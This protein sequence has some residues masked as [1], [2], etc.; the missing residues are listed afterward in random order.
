MI[1]ALVNLKAAMVLLLMSP[2]SISCSNWRLIT[3]NAICITSLVDQML[4]ISTTFYLIK[5]KIYHIPTKG[6]TPN[7]YHPLRWMLYFSWTS[8]TFDSFP[9]SSSCSSTAP[10]RNVTLVCLFVFF[11]LICIWFIYSLWS[12]RKSWLPPSFY[13]QKL[14]I[15]ILL[16]SSVYTTWLLSYSS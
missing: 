14:S 8:D 2:I 5:F 10:P 9:P 1:L 7:A 16:G 11:P 3:P 6:I 15:P 12:S 4:G 13:P